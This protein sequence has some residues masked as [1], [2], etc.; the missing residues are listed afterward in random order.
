MAASRK[1]GAAIVQADAVVATGFNDAP[2]GQASDVHQGH[3]SSELLKRRN[4]ED[5]LA[6]LREVGLIERPLDTD[7]G[8][9]QSRRALEAL[10][11]GELLSVIE[12]QRAV[13]AEAKAID[14]AAVRGVSTEGGI[15]YVTTYPCHLCFKHAL[16]ARL[17]RVVYIEP[18]PKSRALEMYP[19]ASK[20]LVPYAGVAPDMYMKIF[21]ERPAFVALEDGT[22][23]PLD[24]R[25][26]L[27]LVGGLSNDANRVDQERIAVAGLKEEYR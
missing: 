5:T 16:S 19:D 11:G 4:V 9:E 21:D 1:V 15:L 20:K 14:D 22:F 17:D 6:R 18:Y 23:P 25:G 13:H 2:F 26:A 12:Y 7:G 24:R 10:D 8:S 3:D 27:P